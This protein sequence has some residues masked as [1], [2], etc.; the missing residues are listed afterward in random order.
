MLADKMGKDVGDV[1]GVIIAPVVRSLHRHIEHLH[2]SCQSNR[3]RQLH[4]V[5]IERLDINVLFTERVAN[6]GGG[7]LLREH[8]PVVITPTCPDNLLAVVF[9]FQDG[10]GFSKADTLINLSLS[11]RGQFGAVVANLRPFRTHQ[12]TSSIRWCRCGQVQPAQANLD[13]LLDLTG[14]W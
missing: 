12:N 7:T 14:R 9:L 3:G 1:P 5:G 6:A 10:A 8:A 4:L 2:R 11:E 13:N